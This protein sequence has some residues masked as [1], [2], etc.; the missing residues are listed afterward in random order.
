MLFNTE[1]EYRHQAHSHSIQP[2]SCVDQHVRCR[3]FICGLNSWE[4]R[5]C[6]QQYR[7]CASRGNYLSKYTVFGQLADGQLQ[8]V[9]FVKLQ[10]FW[11]AHKL[12]QI[13]VCSEQARSD[14]HIKIKRCKLMCFCV[15]LFVLL[16]FMFL[17]CFVHTGT[18]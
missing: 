14:F 1:V 6:K 13:F 2:I 15:F 8:N 11:S 17:C 12:I 7:T 5:S 4:L 18:Q 3:R 9:R 10:C 16:L